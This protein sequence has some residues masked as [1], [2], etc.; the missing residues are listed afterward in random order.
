MTQQQPPNQGS[1]PL[2]NLIRGFVQ[3]VAKPFV[4]AERAMKAFDAV[5]AVA[6]HDARA[7]EAVL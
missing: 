3:T 7:H 4:D 1:G 2:A 5:Q 6:P